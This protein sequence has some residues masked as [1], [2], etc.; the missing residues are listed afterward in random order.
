[1]LGI[2]DITTAVNI[3]V[4]SAPYIPLKFKSPTGS[5]IS[6]GVCIK[7]KGI[8]RSFHAP[9]KLNTAIVTKAGVVNGRI[10]L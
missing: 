8:K 9:R 10:I 6:S 4:S 1:M 5:V 2:A 7:T 3:L